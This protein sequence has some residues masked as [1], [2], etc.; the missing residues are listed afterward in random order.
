MRRLVIWYLK[1]EKKKI[2]IL[3]DEINYPI[4]FTEEYNLLYYQ[5]LIMSIGKV[6]KWLE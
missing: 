4:N 6:I 5:Q 1:K 3:R 2:A